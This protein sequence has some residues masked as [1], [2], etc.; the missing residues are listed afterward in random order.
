MS[1]AS[2]MNVAN[3][4]YFMGHA[5]G[6]LKDIGYRIYKRKFCLSNISQTFVKVINAQFSIQKLPLLNP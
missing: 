2:M 6:F 3:L 5:N 4:I 1:V